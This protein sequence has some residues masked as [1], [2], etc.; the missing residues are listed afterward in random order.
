M[1]PFLGTRFSLSFPNFS[2]HHP[3]Q[4]GTLLKGGYKE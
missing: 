2:G 3:L 1:S 4:A